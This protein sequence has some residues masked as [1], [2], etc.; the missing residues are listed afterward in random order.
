MAHVVGPKG[1]VVIEKPLREALGLEPGWVT[2]QKL[3][4]DHLEIFFFPPE[5][6]SSLRGVLSDEIRRKVPPRAWRQARERAW[7]EAAARHRPRRRSR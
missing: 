1:Q 6:G 7:D 2:V 5:H 3:V 4:G